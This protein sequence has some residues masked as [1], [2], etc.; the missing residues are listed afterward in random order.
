MYGEYPV[1]HRI[2]Q[3]EKWIKKEKYVKLK[4][5]NDLSKWG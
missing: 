2:I 3:Y 1:M 4:N 5:R